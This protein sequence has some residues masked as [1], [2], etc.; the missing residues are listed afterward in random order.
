MPS[1]YWP[2]GLGVQTI[3]KPT[4]AD[5]SP[6]HAADLEKPAKPPTDATVR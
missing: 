1:G 4:R 5:L 3:W 2:R 6:P